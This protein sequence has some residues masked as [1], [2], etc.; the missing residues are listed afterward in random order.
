MSL[1]V[2]ILRTNMD[3]LSVSQ[4]I[5]SYYN[6][7]FTFS[8]LSLDTIFVLFASQVMGIFGVLFYR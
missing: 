1:T 7:T 5:H 3:M 8:P 6:Y 4:D 2:K